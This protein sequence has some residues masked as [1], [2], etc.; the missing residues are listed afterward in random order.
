MLAA[1]PA[2]GIMPEPELAIQSAEAARNC[3][4]HLPEAVG[5]IQA[6]LCHTQAE[7]HQLANCNH[8][9]HAVA[10]SQQHAIGQMA[11]DL[12]ATQHALDW[13]EGARQEEQRSADVLAGGIDHLNELCAGE[14]AGRVHAEQ[15]LQ[16]VVSGTMNWL[17]QVRSSLSQLQGQIPQGGG[18]PTPASP[19]LQLAQ[20]EAARRPMSPERTG[21]MPL[22]PRVPNEHG[23][24]LQAG[25]G[26]QAYLT[27]DAAMG[28]LSGVTRNAA[29]RAQLGL[30]E[31][32]R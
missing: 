15:A 8:E 13:T 9:L 29:I 31:H 19:Q 3:L 22:M 30:C 20:A 16:H 24:G 23:L 10:E 32:I 25:L 2:G 5:L 27:R 14:Y 11:C 21:R 6:E 28:K 17:D 18:M 4:R 7:N 12:E 26:K 1:H